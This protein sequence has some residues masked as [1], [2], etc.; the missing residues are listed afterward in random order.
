MIKKNE[1]SID[2]I[3][4]QNIITAEPNYKL[5]Q[6]MNWLYLAKMKIY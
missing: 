4:K 2:G 5:N 3:S 1:T 6:E